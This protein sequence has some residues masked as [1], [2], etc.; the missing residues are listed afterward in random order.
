MRVVQALDAGAVLRDRR[1][2][3][4]GPDDTSAEVEHDLAQLGADAARRASS[5]T[6]PPGAPSRHRRT[7]RAPPTRTGCRRTRGCST[8]AGRARDL[9]TT[10]AGSSP[11][12]MAWSTIDGRRVIVVRAR[13]AAGAGRGG[14]RARHH[15]RRHEG[16]RAG[17]DGRRAYSKSSPC[18]PKAGARCRR[19]TSPR[20]IGWRRHALR[21]RAAS[22]APRPPRRPD[23]DGRAGPPSGPP[24]ASPCRRTRHRS[25]RRPRRGAAATSP[26]NAIARS[27]RKSSIGTL[28][29][30]ARA[31]SR[32]RVGRRAGHRG[33]RRRGARHPADLG[34]T[35]CCTSIA[36]PPPP[37]WTTRSACAASS[38]HSRRDG[39][40]QRDPAPH[41]PDRAPPAVAGADDRPGR[42]PQRDVVASGVARRP[43]ARAARV[44]RR[45]R[46][47]VR[48]NN[49]PA[50]IDAAGEHGCAISARRSSARA[51]PRRGVGTRPCALRARR[52]RCRRRQPARTP[53]AREGLFVV[54]DEASQL[55][56]AFAAPA[57]GRARARCLR[58][59]R[60][61]DRA[62]GRGAARHRAAGGVRCPRRGASACFARRCARPAC[63]ACAIVQHDLLQGAP[64][65]HVSTRCSSTRRAR[66]WERSGAIRTSAGRGVRRTSPAFAARA[67]RGC[68]TTPPRRSARRAC[69]STATCSSEPE[70]NEHGRR[71][72]PGGAPGVRARGS[73]GRSA[74]CRP[75]ALGA[76]LD[77]RGCLRT[78]ARRARAGGVLRGPA[79]PPLT[80]AVGRLVCR[81]A[82]C[83]TVLERHGRTPAP[84]IGRTIVLIARA[85]GHVRAVHRRHDAGGAARPRG[86][87]AEGGR[88][89]ARRRPA[90][91]MEAAGLTLK[92]RRQPAVRREGARWAGSRPRTRRPGLVVR[93]GRSV[94]VWISAGLALVARAEAGRRARA[95]RPGPAPA[96]RPRTGGGRRHPVVASS[97]PMPSSRRIRAPGSRATRASA[98]SSTA[99][100]APAA[101]SCPT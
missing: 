96:G 27:P 101:T 71:R 63:T 8:G 17:A 88:P 87:R 7:T 44:R 36:C 15:P 56:G 59:A 90:A 18:S 95:H 14:A 93:R 68:S 45:A 55:V 54:Q 60:R 86:Q 2:R 84:G 29:W 28:R 33:V 92:S 5:T 94:R 79:A 12:R 91:A 10:C 37:P 82:S 61:Q 69:S 41:Q 58:G 57:P 97:R 6:S 50:P 100:S 80:G 1:P 89:R 16:R 74:G 3:P 67:G 40:R 35:S 20:A 39:R 75:G 4:I 78:L 70:E 22:A 19:G 23:A 98:C 81:F 83:S 52:P 34:A 13:L 43:L 99:A 30:R 42:A 38:G 49:A 85:G 65:R 47:W 76:C 9:T 11:G 26:T 62:A 53:L 31:R 24:H 66:A 32:H 72:V 21:R 48:F 46:A 64:F 51:R 73:R 25:G 77:E